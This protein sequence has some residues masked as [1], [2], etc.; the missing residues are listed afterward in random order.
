MRKTMRANWNLFW[1]SFRSHLRLTSVRPTFQIV[2]LAQPIVLD[3]I[4]IM[5]YRNGGSEESF[6]S[7]VLLGSGIAGIWSGVAFSSAG[8][9]NRE[10][11]YGTLGT[12][13]ISPSPLFLVM[14]GKLMG[15][16]LLSLFSLI[17]SFVFSWIVLGIPVEIPHVGHLLLAL[18]VFLIAVNFFALALSN[19]FLLTRSAVVLQNFLEYPILIVTGVLFPVSS[20]PEWLHPLGWPIP[21]TW[22]AEAI[23]LTAQS[24][25]NGWAFWRVLGIEVGL[26]VFYLLLGLFLFRQIEH[27]VRVTASLELY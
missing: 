24:G 2:I 7:F 17:V 14:L 21:L 13:F 5:V 16:G 26:S 19:V 1:Q 23:R 20:L 27:R 4:S 10:R 15:N 3:T 6:M 11:F 22:G 18:F 9:I 12:V 25:W 8:D